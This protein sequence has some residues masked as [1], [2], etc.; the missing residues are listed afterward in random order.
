[1]DE[2]VPQC[3]TAM[4]D[5]VGD[6]NREATARLLPLVYRELR[7]LAGSFFQ[8][9]RPDHTLQPTALVH[10]AYLR[11]AAVEGPQWASRGHFFEVAAK[12]MRHI[13]TDHARAN[14][15][16]KRGRDW[17]P[18]TISQQVALTSSADYLDPL[19]L[20]EA[21]S[22]LERLHRRQGRVVELRFLAGLSFEQIAEALGISSRTVER[23]WRTARAFLR[24]EL[25][26]ERTS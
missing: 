2:S 20:D 1:M 14:L 4:L 9:E 25:K 10:E 7:A 16:Q 23:E 11:L 12:V 5:Q 8:G 24:L 13:L 17:T 6:G 22:K 21:L 19:A 3:L 15:A 26:A 18:V